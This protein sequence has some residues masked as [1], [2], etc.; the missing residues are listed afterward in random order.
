MQQAALEE[1]D[2][3]A[4]CGTRL[5]ALNARPS[6]LN[7]LWYVL[8][9]ALGAAASA[10]GDAWSLGFVVETERQVIAHLDKHLKQLPTADQKSALI[11]TQ[12]KAEEAQHAHTAHSN[13]AR[14]LPG[15]MRWLMRQ[16][17]RVMTTTAY[18]I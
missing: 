2:H 6:T 13:G 11:L 10:S 16:W 18:W 8:S 15:P 14:P 1:N 17:S 9:F 3:L 4:W 12:M 7:P 5:K